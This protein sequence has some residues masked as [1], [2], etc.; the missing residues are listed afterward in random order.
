MEFYIYICLS[1]CSNGIFSWERD[2]RPLDSLGA[3]VLSSS[4]PR[5]LRLLSAHVDIMAKQRHRSKPKIVANNYN[6]QDRH[7]FTIF[8]SYP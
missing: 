1:L 5:L 3:L 8:S 4:V 6:L 7:F 2:D